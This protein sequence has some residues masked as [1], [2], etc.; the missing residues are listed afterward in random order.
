MC[1]KMCENENIEYLLISDAAE[2]LGVS[3]QTLR[4]WIK[5]GYIECITLPSGHRRFDRKEVERVLQENKKT[6]KGAE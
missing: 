5:K 1:E 4:R 6:T 3:G 2:I